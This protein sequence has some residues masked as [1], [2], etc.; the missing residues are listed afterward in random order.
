LLV[1]PSE[2]LFLAARSLLSV[3]GAG[4][5]EL[6]W[7][8]SREAGLKL[9]VQAEHDGFLL[10]D[11]PPAWDGV[12]L[13]REAVNQGCRAPIVLLA[14]P[15]ASQ[16]DEEALRAGAAGFLGK[17]QLTAEGLERTLRYTIEHYRSIE[18]MRRSQEF[19]RNLIECSLDMIIAVDAQRRIVEFNKAA[20]K[21]FGYEPHEVLG[22][23]VDML[24]AN[25]ED[26]LQ[27]G[28]ALSAQPSCVREIWNVRKNGEFFPSVISASILRDTAGRQLGAMGISRDISERKK[29]EAALRKLT[30]DLRQRVDDRSSQLETANRELQAQVLER[31]KLEAE[32]EQVIRDLSDA[33]AKVKTLTG[34]LPM[35]AH[36]K[37]IRDDQ[38]AWQNIEDYLT[39]HSSAEFTHGICPTCATEHFREVAGSSPPRGKK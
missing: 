5:V 6:E 30:E 16:R 14:S 24:Y 31:Q 15:S 7:V 19:S 29:T 4:Q 2:S 8:P 38:G 28:N 12:K 17:S 33:L 21:A 13:L 22:R 18:T 10:D 37:K 39:R 3:G 32:R 23:H 36:C 26:S 34:L 9:L 27:V 25:P 11:A 1:G 20:Q 35:C